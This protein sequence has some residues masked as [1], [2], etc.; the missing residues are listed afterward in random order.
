MKLASLTF[1]PKVGLYLGLGIILSSCVS[2]EEILEGERINITNANLIITDEFKASGRPS[3]GRASQL[4]NWTQGSGTLANNPGNVVI[5][6]ENPENPV[7]TVDIGV[8]SSGRL[9]GGGTLRLA[10]RP[11]VYQDRILTYEHN[12][13]IISFDLVNGSKYWEVSLKPDEEDGAGLGGGIAA[14][15]GRILLRQVMVS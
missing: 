1:L 13:R 7:W 9:L 8:D 10:A 6:A 4:S 3:V 15:R 5:S 11:L 2:D 12:A 14:D